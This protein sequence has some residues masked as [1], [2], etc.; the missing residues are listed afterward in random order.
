MRA[1]VAIVG[2]GLAG[3]L[4]ATVLGRAGYTTIIVDPHDTYPD[5]FRCEKLEIGRV[6][7]LDRLGVG[8]AVVRASTHMD[9]MWIARRGRLIDKRPFHQ[10]GIAYQDLVNTVRAEI[11]PSVSKV[12]T[13]VTAI[14]PG[15]KTQ[16]IHLKN[17]DSIEAK[18]TIIA[19]GLNWTLRSGLGI[20][21]EVSSPRHS[22]SIGFDI[23][24]KDKADFDFQALQYNPERVGDLLGY[25]T[26]FRIRQSMRANLFV[27]HDLKHPWIELLRNDPNAAVHT[28]MP[29]LSGLIGDYELV[30]KPKIWPTDLHTMQDYVIPGVVLVGDAFGAACPATG[31]GTFKV[32][33]DIDRLCKVHVPKWME[34]ESLEAGRILEFYR[35]SEKIKCDRLSHDMAYRFKSLAVDT[36]LPRQAE[37]WARFASRALI[38]QTRKYVHGFPAQQMAK[39]RIVESIAPVKTTE[40]SSEAL[41]GARA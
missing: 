36:T 17:G 23:C 9:E 22:I 16:R 7:M 28:L 30:D 11:P 10:Y 18:L 39:A 15:A 6:E 1:E 19:S 34:G 27:Y 14:E 41:R 29:G 40:D 12:R 31:T 3:S 24:R 5:D 2:E 4:A 33:T 25:L 26:L 13:W 32:F 20:K 37:R 21:R 8:G 35:D 38:G